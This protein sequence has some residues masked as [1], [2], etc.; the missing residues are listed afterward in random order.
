LHLEFIPY[1]R[2]IAI[3]SVSGVTAP[4]PIQTGIVSTCDTFYDVHFGDLCYDIAD[5]HCVSLDSF[6]AWNLAVKTD[7]SGL[8]ADNYVCVSVEAA[9]RTGITTPYPNQIGI[10]TTCDGFYKVIA[11][12]SCINIAN[13]N[14]ISVASFY[15]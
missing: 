5:T 11:G 15:A 1:C 8:K 2:K 4:S 10:V 6:S 12:D 3:S 7:S 9:T 14:G 13:T